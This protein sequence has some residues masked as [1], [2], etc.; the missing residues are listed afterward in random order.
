MQGSTE[1]SVPDGTSR[2]PLPSLV[3]TIG[4]LLVTLGA[5][6]PWFTISADLSRFGAGAFSQTLSGQELHGPAVLIAGLLLMGAGVAL[7]ALRGRGTIGLAGV[8]M[9]VGL[10]TTVLCI[11]DIVT[12]KTQ[13]VDAATKAVTSSGV[14]TD[15]AQ[16]I[17]DL[18][19]FNI[20]VQVGA[21]VAVIGAIIGL[22]GSI[23]ALARR[24]KPA[25]VEEPT[26]AAPALDP[27]VPAALPDEETP[28]TA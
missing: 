13:A 7:A 2:P 1:P 17:L 15:Q 14:P 9:L 24:P 10:A 12:S 20:S 25:P 26:V 8:G 23:L 5:F 18:F 22:V 27:A 28:S 16:R 11:N 6:L 21:F 19:H 4:G 3:C